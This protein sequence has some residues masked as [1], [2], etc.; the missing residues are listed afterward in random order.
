[1]AQVAII[2]CRHFLGRRIFQ[3]SIKISIFAVAVF[4]QEGEFRF[5]Y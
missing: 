5:A 1:M 2:E 3:A 4:T